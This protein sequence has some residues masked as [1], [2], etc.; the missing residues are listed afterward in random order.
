[1][2]LDA[3]VRPEQAVEVVTAIATIFREQQGLRESRDRARLKHLFLKEG[4]TAET[5]LNELQSRLPFRLEP[6]VKEDGSGRCCC[7]TTWAFIANGRQ[8]STTSVRRC[9]AGG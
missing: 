6:A 7:V 9:C 1:M 4:W 3:F 2:R 8:V 5:F